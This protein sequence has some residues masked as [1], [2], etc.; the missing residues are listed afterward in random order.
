MNAIKA[1]RA[2]AIDRDST[3]M[4]LAASTVNDMNGNPVV[5]VNTPAQ[6]VRD[7]GYD[8]TSP[9]L[10]EFDLNMT[11]ES[12]SLTFSET[13]SSETVEPKM[14]M[15]QGSPSS[16]GY[17]LTG[18]NVSAADS[19]IITIQINHRD[20][21]EL[22]RQLAIATAEET[23][24]LTFSDKLL[25]DTAGNPAADRGGPPASAAALQ[26]DVFTRDSTRPVIEQFSFDMTL[27]LLTMSFSETMNASSI[28]HSKI[29]FQS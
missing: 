2:L 13:I 27:G 11:A 6:K 1:L 17:L 9:V 23:T 29:T 7:Y 14:L 19:T 24:F 26:V 28:N 16:S 8:I 5:A 22:K 4:A 3:Y 10:E 15:L 25:N 12:I 20:M 18:G 21:N